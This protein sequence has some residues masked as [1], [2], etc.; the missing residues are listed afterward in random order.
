MCTSGFGTPAEGV[1][2]CLVI[3]GRSRPFRHSHEAHGVS[4]FRISMISVTPDADE[5]MVARAAAARIPVHS[6]QKRPALSRISSSKSASALKRLLCRE[7][8]PRV[9]GLHRRSLAEACAGGL[10]PTLEH[11][12]LPWRNRMLQ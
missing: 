4:L 5:T 12:L 8:L 1:V 2:H 9:P 10:Q 3:L 11:H 6:T 7:R